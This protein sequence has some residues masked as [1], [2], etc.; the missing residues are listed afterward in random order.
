MFYLERYPYNIKTHTIIDNGISYCSNLNISS[1]KGG[2]NSCDNKPKVSEWLVTELKQ[3]FFFFKV[4]I[5]IHKDS[6]D[7][8][9]GGEFILLMISL[10]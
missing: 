6:F 7:N 1:S 9:T 10:R 4:A 8:E 2:L 5:P 3:D